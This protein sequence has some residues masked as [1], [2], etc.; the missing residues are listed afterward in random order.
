MRKL[1]PP[2]TEEEEREILQRPF[3]ARGRLLLLQRHYQEN[4]YSSEVTN[5]AVAMLVMV[6]EELKEITAKS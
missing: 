3:Y 5:T 6:D 4:L 1:L 2:L